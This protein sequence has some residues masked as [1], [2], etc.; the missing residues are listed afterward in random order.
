LTQLNRDKYISRDRDLSSFKLFERD[1][2]TCIYCGKSSINDGVKLVMDHIYPRNMGGKN[3]ISNM[4][5]SCVECNAQK[6]DSLLQQDIILDLWKR[7]QSLM[8]K[9]DVVEQ[10]DSLLSHLNHYYKES[11]GES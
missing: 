4:V 1:N 7:N 2:F 10:Y 5:T 8:N 6:K 9:L 11:K 3:D